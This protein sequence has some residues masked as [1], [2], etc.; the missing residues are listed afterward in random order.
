MNPT[1][2]V[3]VLSLCHKQGAPG[4]PGIPGPTGFA[5]PTVSSMDLLKEFCIVYVFKELA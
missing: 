2:N 4:V 5:G 1:I 3:I